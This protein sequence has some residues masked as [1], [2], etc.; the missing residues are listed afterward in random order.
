[1]HVM[2]TGRRYDMVM[3]NHSAYCACR[4]GWNMYAMDML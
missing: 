3:Y 1:M 2:N 4:G